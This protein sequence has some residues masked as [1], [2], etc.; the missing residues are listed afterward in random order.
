MP[1]CP[2]P[3][4]IDLAAFKEWSCQGTFLDLP[5][6]VSDPN[7]GEL[8]WSWGVARGYCIGADPE[9]KIPSRRHSAGRYSTIM[10]DG[11]PTSAVDYLTRK[12]LKAYCQPAIL[13]PMPSAPLRP[14]IMAAPDPYVPPPAQY[15]GPLVPV[16]APAPAPAPS[17]TIP[18]STR[19][20]MTTFMNQPISFGGTGPGPV[21]SQQPWIPT[22]GSGSFWDPIISGA[23]E[24]VSRQVFG[25]STPGST[26]PGYTTPGITGG[27]PTG[28]KW[29]GQECVAEGIKGWTQRVIPGGESGVYEG[30]AS[31]LLPGA[32]AP[33]FVNR[34]T[35]MCP[36]GFVLGR[37]GA[38]YDRRVIPNKLRKY[39]RGR[40]PLLTGGEMKVLTKARSLEGKVKRAWTAAGKPGQT[41]PR[42]SC[43]K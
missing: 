28:Y 6:D 15:S 35:A 43:K 18:V 39:P 30:S 31:G 33:Q 26:D 17:K 4:R 34:V 36:T 2:P 24:W 29:N 14:P 1:P 8:T 10:L 42:R 23:G 40:R 19:T 32:E 16:V 9:K 21:S 38:C 12:S 41:R 13:P 37:D 25:G 3:A 20:S 11:V 27:C 7:Y 22:G 5:P